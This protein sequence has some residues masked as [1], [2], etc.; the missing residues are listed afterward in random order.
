MS[1]TDD[2]DARH[3][4]MLAELAEAGMGLARA[5][6]AASQT[7]V[8]N[9]DYAL[10][11]RAFHTV[12]R[13]VRQTIALELKLRH[14]PRWPAPAKPEPEPAPSPPPERRVRPEQVS[15]NE[16]ER[17]DWNEPLDEA[18]DSGD[19]AA[20]NA[21]I[22]AS[23]AR[24][25]RSLTRAGRVL[26]NAGRPTTARHPGRPAGAIRDPVSSSLAVRP[27]TRGALLS[28]ASPLDPG[29]PL[30]AGPGES[31]GGGK[32][33]RPPPWRNSG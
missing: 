6:Y 32:A 12:S 25:Q 17:A 31:G 28:S 20:I 15:W 9:Q 29:A 24:I 19:A 22:D 14:E 7:T 4:R 2:M 23:V 3:G 33:L 10:L 16:Y 1:S 21:A 30:R 11:A 27:R 8:S 13:S 26:D 5:L 18:L